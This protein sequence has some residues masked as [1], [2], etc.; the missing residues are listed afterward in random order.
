MNQIMTHL[1]KSLRI[2][3]IKRDINST[4]VERCIPW[5]KTLEFLSLYWHKHTKK[6]KN[7]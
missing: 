2:E 3:T 7:M 4:W 6:R 5:S 1:A